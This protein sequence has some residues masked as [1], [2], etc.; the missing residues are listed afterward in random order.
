MPGMPDI[1]YEL[2]LQ[3]DRALRRKRRPSQPSGEMFNFPEHTEEP[4]FPEAATI[5]ASDPEIPAT[6]PI[7]DIE[8]QIHEAIA[9]YLNLARLRELVALGQDITDA[10]R[11]TADPPPEL[12]QLLGLLG[13]LLRPARRE[14]IKS[15]DDLA[16]LLMLEM[17]HL[18]QEQ[19]R[20]ACLDTK[21]YLQKIH[22][23][24]QGSLN[25]SIVRVGEIYKE[26]IR[27]NSAAII[28]IHNHP[29]G[30]PGPSP[31]DVTVT[32][33]IVAAGKLL[34]IECLDHLI[35]GQGKYESLRRLGLGF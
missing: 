14:Q 28:V 6:E 33:E 1:D 29:S 3:K 34:D 7:P 18:D 11:R 30:Q 4:A 8:R 27:L 32:R 19:L 13:I 23:V 26:A 20:V 10:L 22:L 24:Y 21:N 2:I 5:F 15:P 9:P 16:G 12:Q 35:I 17:G 31:E 25:A